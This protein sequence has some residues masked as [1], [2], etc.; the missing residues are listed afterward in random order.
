MFLSVL[1]T[2]ID[3]MS[4]NVTMTTDIESDELFHSMNGPIG[5]VHIIRHSALVV[6]F[7]DPSSRGEIAFGVGGRVPPLDCGTAG[8]A[9][10]RAKRSRRNRAESKAARLHAREHAG[11]GIPH[12]RLTY[13][14]NAAHK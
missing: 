2:Y 13:A 6:A 8:R 14:C 12:G 7:V 4:Q 1:T 3:G 10:S 11:E 9:E 5:F